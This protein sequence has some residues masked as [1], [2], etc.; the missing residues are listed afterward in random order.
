MSGHRL[1]T[2]KNHFRDLDITFDEGKFFVLV[3]VDRAATTI[4]RKKINDILYRRHPYFA[5]EQLM[6]PF[7]KE[8][9][10]PWCREYNWIKAKMS[11]FSETVDLGFVKKRYE[12]LQNL[13]CGLTQN[14]FLPGI[15]GPPKNLGPTAEFGPSTMNDVEVFASV[16]STLQHLRDMGKLSENRLI[17][18]DHVLESERTVEGRYYDT[19]ITASL[20]RGCRDHDLR[21]HAQ[22]KRLIEEFT[23]RLA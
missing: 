21:A 1:R 16:A 6:L 11:T 23:A 2:F 20:L 9:D 8:Q 15:G 4:D 7:W 17:P 19:V 10:C 5:V 14:A 18:V 13:D 3:G 12:Q 22:D